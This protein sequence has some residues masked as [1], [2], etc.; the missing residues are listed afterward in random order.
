MTRFRIRRMEP[1][2][3]A[4][5]N[6]IYNRLVAGRRSQRSIEVMRHI[7][8]DGPGGPVRSWIAEAQTNSGEWKIVAHHG[9]CPIRY[10]M[11]AEEF[12]FAKTVNSFL[13]PEFSDKFLYLRFEQR[14][15]AEVEGAFDAT[16]TLTPKA[17][18]MR[19][20]LGYDTSIL[21]LDYERGLQPVEIASRILIRL[22]NR[23]AGSRIPEAARQWGVFFSRGDS[24]IRLEEMNA[25]AALSSPFFDDFWPEARLSAGLAPRRDAADL[26]WRF[27]NMPWHYTTLTYTW[28]DA[29]RAYGVIHQGAPLHFALEDICI[30]RPRPEL[31]R[32]FLEGIFAWSRRKGALMV[33]FMTTSDGHPA[34]MLKIY[35]NSMSKSLSRKY[36]DSH[37]SRRLTVRGRQRLGDIWPPCNVTPIIAMA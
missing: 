1:A 20:A 30:S 18:R 13:L 31:L 28:P 21:E 2:D 7:W 3:E 35:Q 25:A 34:E 37:M 9:L 11:A 29:T 36:R 19:A 16:Y 32:E 17:A 15:L 4:P 12:I 23:Y 5:F 8:H 22:A 24:K 10:T 6:D 26:A 27:W 33:S 14:C